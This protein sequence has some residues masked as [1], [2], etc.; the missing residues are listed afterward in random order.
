MRAKRGLGIKK[1]APEL[2]VTYSY[3]SKLENDEAN[4]SEEMVG[5]VA[6]YFNYD[7]NA[8]LL[9]AGKIPAEIL[10]ILQDNPEEALSFLRSHFRRREK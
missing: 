9:T 4:P 2:G 8:L 3:L 6:R 7:P 10:K 5:K 1:L